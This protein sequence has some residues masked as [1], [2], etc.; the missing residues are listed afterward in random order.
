MAIRPVPSDLPPLPRLLVVT[1]TAKGANGQGR[2]TFRLSR[3][4]ARLDGRPRRRRND[5]LVPPAAPRRAPSS[6]SPPRGRRD[7]ILAHRPPVHK[8]LPIALWL[9]DHGG[10]NP[11]AVSRVPGRRCVICRASAGT[12][13]NPGHFPSCGVTFVSAWTLVENPAGPDGTNWQLFR[14]GWL[15]AGPQVSRLGSPKVLMRRR[16]GRPTYRLTHAPYTIIMRKISIS[17]MHPSKN[18]RIFSAYLLM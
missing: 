9:V 13:L 1:I 12:P 4:A 3:P 17:L 11:R 14:R 2:E 7:G 6:P 5:R 18:L 8:A 16:P 15:W 10:D